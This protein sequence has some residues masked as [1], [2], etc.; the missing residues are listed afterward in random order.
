MSFAGPPGFRPLLPTIHTTSPECC[1]NFA[2]ALGTS[3]FTS[4]AWG[5][6]NTL[7][8]GFPLILP[9]AYTVAKIG[10]ANAA[11]ITGTVDAGVYDE[12]GNRIFSARNKNGDSNISHANASAMQSFTINQTLPAGKYYLFFTLSGTTATVLSAPTTAVKGAACGLVQ[13]TV[14]TAILASTLTYAL[15]AQTFVPW[16]GITNRSTQ[17]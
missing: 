12:A 9:V 4:T 16:V 1:G 13:A 15:F 11:T 8:I 7:A 6:T 17:F 3:S 5:T 14:S 10:W 2:K